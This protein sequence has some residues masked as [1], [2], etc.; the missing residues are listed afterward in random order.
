MKIRLSLLTMAICSSMAAN[1]KSVDDMS[2]LTV[3][4]NHNSSLIKNFNPYVP[5]RM[6]TARDFIYEPMVIF[7]ELKGNTPEFRLATNYAFSDDLMSIT[8][9][10]RDGVKWSDGETFSADDVVFSFDLIKEHSGLDD[11]GIHALIE[12]VEKVDDLTVKFTLKEVN[13]NAAYEISLVPV[14]AEH[15]WAKVEDPMHFMNEEPVGTGAF[16][17]FP[18]FTPQLFLQC[19]N[20]NYWDAAELDID[21]LRVPQYN[22]NDQVMASLIHSEV[23]WGGS[24]I[25]DIDTTY[26]AA[27]EHHGY[28]YPAAGTQAFMF[29]F[30]HSDPVKQEVL[31]NIDFRRAFSM[32]LDRQTIIDIAH[33]GS[34]TINDFAS[35]LGYAFEAWSDETVHNEFKPFM[36]F[37]LEGS[38]ALLAEAGFKDV[39]GDGFVESPSGKPFS[40]QIQSPNGWTDFNNSVMLAVE[41]LEAAGIKAEPRT[42]DFAVYNQS[43]QNAE[44]DVAY[45]NYF[46]GPTPHTYW[47][48]AYHSKLQAEGGLPRFAMHFWTNAELDALLDSFFRTDKQAEQVKIAHQIQRIIASNQ[49]TVPVMSGSNFYQYNTKDFTGWWTAEN[50]KGRP[51]IWEGTP[52]RILHVLDLSPRS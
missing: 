30:T 40:L 17:E 47:N 1:A 36:T 51:M 2:Q 44:Y 43:M 24:F 18:V 32:A 20:P 45:T 4:P 8:F 21:C 23:D 19:R 49:V 9:D 25:P 29:N 27:S 52:E 31:S 34:G 28:W 16:T 10:L 22:H 37:N 11:R 6:H 7:N 42:P 38:K 35:G 41:Q 48:S 39:D 14:V 12:S 13:T 50:P 5:A 33:Y 46:H 3:I 15:V 26:V